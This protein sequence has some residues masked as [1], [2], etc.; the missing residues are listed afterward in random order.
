[1]NT[2]TSINSLGYIPAI[3][4]KNVIGIG[5]PVRSAVKAANRKVSGFFNSCPSMAA[6]WE[7]RKARRL[8]RAVSGSPILSSCRP[9]WTR[10]GSYPTTQFA[11]SIMAQLSLGTSV[12]SLSVIN[13]KAFTTS[14][15]VA[16]HFGKRHDAVLRDIRNLITELPSDHAHNFVEMVVTVQ[17]GSGATRNDP[18]YRI[19]RDGFTLLAMGFTGKKALAFKLAYI[20]AFNRMEAE[21]ASRQS[22]PLT[23][24][25]RNNI[26]GLCTHMLWLNSWW[27]VY[28]PAIRGMNS[29]TA[30]QVHDHFLDG[31]SFA[32]N[33]AKSTD[34]ELDE[35][36]VRNYPWH[37]DFSVRHAYFTQQQAKRRLS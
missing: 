37:Q 28:G 2:L 3:T 34:C 36:Y 8:A 1:M 19:T 6:R 30:S 5:L 9:D 33:V 22:T 7:S 31:A 12:P 26:A 20:D 35:E 4:E 23:D 18:A 24:S 14:T 13:G 25:T 15:D 32:R 11:R 27:R 10:D 16:R 29:D 21:L 17:I